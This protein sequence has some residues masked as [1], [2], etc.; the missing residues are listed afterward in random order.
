[1]SHDGTKGS[2]IDSDAGMLNLACFDLM[3]IELVPMA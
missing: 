2:V 1:M 3:L